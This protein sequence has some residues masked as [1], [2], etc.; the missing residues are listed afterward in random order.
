LTLSF[1]KMIITTNRISPEIIS[2]FGKTLFL[3]ECKTVD[4][5]ISH[6]TDIS[7]CKIG[8]TLICAEFLSEF[9]KTE[10]P[11]VKIISG[12]NPSSPY[13]DDILYN[14]AVV[15]KFV[16]CNV[17]YTA[18][19]ILNEAEKQNIKIINVKQG[20]AKC[21]VIPVTDNAIITS[22]FSVAKAAESVGIEVL[23]V[24][25]ENITLDGFDNGFIGGTAV[26]TDG[27]VIFAGDLSRSPHKNIIV[28][29]IESHG[30]TVKYIENMPLYD[31]G[32]PIYIP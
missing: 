8:N 28:N 31:I 7:L 3:P 1:I 2:L 16:F 12:R 5:R 13:P 11:N 30:K 20:Y 15:G 27:S 23:T 29:F 9:L 14:A 6:H 10:L 25:N 19:E 17:K 18:S 21:S 22:D 4:K 32:S 24:T 26:S